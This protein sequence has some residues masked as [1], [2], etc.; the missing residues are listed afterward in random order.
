MGPEKKAA[1]LSLRISD[2]AREVCMTAEK[3]V[4]G[5]LDVAEQILK[6]SGERF[7]PDGSDIIFQDVVKFMYFRRANQEMDTYLLEF[8]VLRQKGET[9]MLMGAGF[10]NDFAPALCM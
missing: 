1:R 7:A 6:I 3:D 5:N 2:V 10:P 8:D 9:R 4:V